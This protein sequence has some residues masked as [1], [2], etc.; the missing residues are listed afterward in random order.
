[1]S[2]PNEDL[3]ARI[4]AL[5]SAIDA[6]RDE[7]QQPPRGPLGLPRPP[8]PP[9]LLNF[10]SE[11]AIPAAIATLEASVRSLEALQAGLRLLE[12]G[13]QTAD[14][15]D[16]S[17][18]RAQTRGA[19]TLTRLESALSDLDDAVDSRGPVQDSAEEA[20][21][22]AQRLTTEIRRDLAERTALDDLPRESPMEPAPTPEAT[23]VDID[24][25]EELETIKDEVDG[26]S[27][28]GDDRSE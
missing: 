27:D 17:Q 6:L 3:E 28:Q 21:Q 24:V 4:D 7:L 25:D 14:V 1:M 23:T 2:R 13:D 18:R 22:T 11:Q 19:S 5:E 8:T 10:S 12:Q 26:S 16:S 15:F 20:L 9:E